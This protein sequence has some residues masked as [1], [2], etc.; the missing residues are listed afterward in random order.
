MGKKWWRVEST[1]HL[2]L[3]TSPPQ[4]IGMKDGSV[5]L[6]DLTTDTQLWQVTPHTKEVFSLRWVGHE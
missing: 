1:W 6:Y 5:M 2:T 4:A 3:D